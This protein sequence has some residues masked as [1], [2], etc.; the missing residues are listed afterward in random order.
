MAATT[1]LEPQSQFLEEQFKEA[2]KLF[3]AD[4]FDKVCWDAPSI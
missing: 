3:K 4:A 1:D 2:W